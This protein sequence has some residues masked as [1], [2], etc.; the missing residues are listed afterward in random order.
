MQ[1]KETL[2]SFKNKLSTINI[3]QKKKHFLVTMDVSSPLTNK[4]EK[5]CLVLKKLGGRIISSTDYHQ[6]FS[7]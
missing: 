7:F 3:I 5:M 1:I 2:K 4:H 6:K